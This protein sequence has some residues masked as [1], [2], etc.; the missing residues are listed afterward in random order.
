MSCGGDHL[1]ILTHPRVQ[2]RGERVD[3]RGQISTR[4]RSLRGGTL[5]RYHLGR[6]RR[7]RR[8]GYP[9]RR[10]DLCDL[11]VRQHT[12]A[13]HHPQQRMQAPLGGAQS[14]DRRPGHRSTRRQTALGCLT[15][16][17]QW[18]AAQPSVTQQPQRR[19]CCRARCHQSGDQQSPHRSA[20]RGEQTGDQDPEHRAESEEQ[21]EP[22]RPAPLPQQP[23]ARVGD[24]AELLRRCIGVLAD[25]VDA[26]L[27][28]RPPLGRGESR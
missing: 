26:A 12:A 7:H 24:G 11:T 21:A 22:Q 3:G 6:G 4:L 2:L 10:G 23:G 25:S 1:V 19:R 28:H 27:Q 5:H 16:R 8:R 9:R 13:R 20:P 17:R 15:Q 14:R 18:L